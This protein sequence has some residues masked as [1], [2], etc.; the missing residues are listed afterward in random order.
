MKITKH[1]TLDE[2]VFSQTAKRKGIPNNPDT[3]QLANM[4]ALCQHTLEPVRQ[5][6]G[7]PIFITSGFRSQALNGAVGGSKTSAHMD[8]LA[9]DIICPDFGTPAEI[10]E[11][12]GASS[13]EYDQ[14]IY[15]GSW[16][17][18]S[19]ASSPRNEILTAI[20]EDGKAVYHVGLV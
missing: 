20:F 19:W 9:A 7:K 17:H 16:V 5:L 11:V 12:I 3:T 13:I 6:L 14:L 2:L 8:G 4:K 1:F 15:E 18:I 10:A